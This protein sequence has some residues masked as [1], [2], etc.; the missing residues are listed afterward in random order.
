MRKSIY[1]IFLMFITLNITGQSNRFLEEVYDEIKITNDIIYGENATVLYLPVFGE[2]I[3][4][5]LLLDLYEPVG[6]AGSRPLIIYFHSGNFLPFPENLGPVGTRKDSSVVT[7]CK[8]LARCGYV[9]ASAA[10]RLGWNPVAN[11]VD[12][13]KLGLINA[14]YR[15]VQDANTCVRYFKK[16]M[17]EG[18]NPFCIDTSRIV[19]WGDDSGGYIALNAGCLDSYI[20]IPSAPDGKFWYAGLFPM[21]LEHLNGDV[22]AKHYGISTPDN[23]FLPFPVGDTLCYA[24]H[25]KYSSRFSVSV[26]MAGAV[27]DSAWIDP[28]QPPVISVH[29]PYDITTPY[30][31][32]IVYVNLGNGNYL[33]VVEVQGSSVVNSLTTQYGNNAGIALPQ[34]ATPFQIAVSDIGIGRNGGREGLYPILGDTIT[35]DTPWAFWDCPTNPNCAGGL[36]NNPHMSK[37]KAVLYMDTILAYVIPRLYNTLQLN[38]PETNCIVETKE[39]LAS[40]EIDIS[41]SPNPASNDI[42]ITV[43]K[44][45]PIKSIQV[46][47]L[48]G[49]LMNQYGDIQS[50]SYQLSVDHLVPGQYVIKFRFDQGI[51]SRQFVVK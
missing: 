43:E 49:T 17:A 31:E 1:S 22:E 10:Y 33:E 46:Y 3:K 48:K 25:T 6:D 4:E 7:M 47:D 13:R 19:L 29:A 14:A 20:K 40:V 38:S 12:D 26:N 11:S 9:V 8:R 27:G 16:T 42:L 51:T 15:G 5:P 2:A 35:D 37:E 28:G 50:C 32:G 21:V 39:V 24:N 45:Y 36:L 41:I 30:G 23:N 44:D 18:Y 34:N